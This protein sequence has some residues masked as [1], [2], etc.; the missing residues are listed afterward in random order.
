MPCGRAGAA[1]PCGNLLCNTNPCL[2][3]FGRFLG[4]WRC[5]LVGPTSVACQGALVI[6]LSARPLGCGALWETPLFALFAGG[7][8]CGEGLATARGRDLSL[9]RRARGCGLAVRC[10]LAF[11][12]RDSGSL[13]ETGEGLAALLKPR[14]LRDSL[15]KRL[16]TLAVPGQFPWAAAWG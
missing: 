5:L 13:R 16:A 4:H 15:Q 12:G 3:F 10:F 8:C 1:V 6:I 14:A 7:G 9:P 2:C 11:G